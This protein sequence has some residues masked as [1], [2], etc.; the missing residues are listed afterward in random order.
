MGRAIAFRSLSGRDETGQ[1]QT[2]APGRPQT[3]MACPT[4]G[5]AKFVSDLLTYYELRLSSSFVSRHLESGRH[6]Q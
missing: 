4:S 3:T 6:H 2:T 1:P 5:E